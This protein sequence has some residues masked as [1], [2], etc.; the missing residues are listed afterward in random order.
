MTDK[1]QI[2]LALEIGLF[3]VYFGYIL[4]SSGIRML[5]SPSYS[6]DDDVLQVLGN[7]WISLVV[8]LL[9]TFVV[10]VTAP[11]IV[12]PCGELIEGRM[13]GR[14]QGTSIHKRIIIRVLFCIVCI[15]F[16]EFVPN[17]FVR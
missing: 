15:T 12:I 9:M 3:M 11:L 6:F 1:S 13:Y 17:G 10:A 2:K 14:D 7:D 8:R 5:F 16:S 4:I